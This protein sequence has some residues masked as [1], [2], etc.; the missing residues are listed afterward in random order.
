MELMFDRV[1]ALDIAKA[2]LTACVR[3]PGPGGSRASTV[4][5]FGTT[6]GALL[7][8]RDW[9]LDEQVEVVS[10]ESTGVY[11]KP[12][13]YLLEERLRCWLLNAQQVKTV[14]G[15][16]SDVRDAAWLAQLTECGLVR[17][18]FVP[19]PPIRELRN[20]TRY[21]SALVSD[22]SR[23]VQRLEKLMEDTGIKLSAAM[24]SLLTKSGRAMLDAL[25][26]GERDPRVLAEL[27]RGKLRNKRTELA[28]A[29][30]GRF[31]DHH[32]LLVRQM[33]HRIDT[34]NTA[35]DEVEAAIEEAISPFAAQIELLVTIPGVGLRIAEVILAE[36][37]GVMTQFPSAA[38]LASWAG[39]VPGINQ[40]AGRRG[41]S[42]CRPGNKHLQSAMVEA[43]RAASHTKNTYPSA[44]YW[45]LARRGPNK[46]AVA[47]AHSLL[48]AVWHVLTHNT[49]YQD[50]GG[51]YYQHRTDPTRR[52][53]TLVAQLEALGHQVTLQPAA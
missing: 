30:A 3:R 15:R 38:H 11:W 47:V 22:R 31:S 48:V 36:T 2:S 21:R 44:Q 43:A 42:R 33:L 28:Q 32:A 7:V 12:A 20:L 14:P 26:D 8:L 50:L 37:G 53:R 5:T 10:M 40:S 35:I 24:S 6:V 23:E 45:R 49:G 9:L 51:D 29:L 39:L 46:A 16:K 27:A 4:R 19:P 1:A 17:P 25:T 52:T 13:Y 34:T 18:S 41:S